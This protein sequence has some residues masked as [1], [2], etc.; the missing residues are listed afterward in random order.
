VADRLEQRPKVEPATPDSIAEETAAS[1][2]PAQDRGRAFVTLDGPGQGSV[3]CDR[4]VPQRPDWEHVV[5]GM[6]DLVASQ[7]E[8]DPRRIVLVGRSFAGMLA[9]RVAACEPRL[10]AMIVDPGQ[11]DMGAGMP[12]RLSALCGLL[13][14]PAAKPKFE[15]LLQAPGIRT[16]LGPRMVTNGVA[17]P[18]GCFQDMRRHTST[19]QAPLVTCPSFVTDN[20]TDHVST[21]Q[22]EQLYDAL[23]CP[24]A[25]RK[26]TLADGGGALRG[27]GAYRVL[28][29]RVRLAREN[30]ARRFV[31]TS[32]TDHPLPAGNGDHAGWRRIFYNEAGQ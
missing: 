31:V 30:R 3:L 4:R 28:N 9:P 32:R 14:D 22:G 10:A 6:F 21:G 23:T 13:D 26:F 11:I 12:A 20:E 8:V 29:R 15:A 17:D 2:Y 16:L 7:P 18:Q 25:F 1:A 5:P 24:K 19:A 27:H